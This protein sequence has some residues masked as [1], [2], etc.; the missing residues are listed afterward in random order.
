MEREELPDLGRRDVLGNLS[1]FIG[2]GEEETRRSFAAALPASM[3]AIAEHGSSER[4]ARDLMEGMRSGEAPQLDVNDVAATLSDAQ[5]SDRLLVRSG[6]WLERLLGGRMNGILGALSTHGGL[7]RDATSKVMALAAPLALGLVG[8]RVREDGL[9]ADALADFL[10]SEKD[11][12]GAQVPAPLL[13]LLG[14]ERAAMRDEVRPEAS[15]LER[16]PWRWLFVIVAS[17]I[18]LGYLVFRGERPVGRTVGAPMI[19]L[20]RPAPAVT[21]ES[22]GMRPLA[23]FLSS[24]QKGEQRFVANNLTFTTDERG[25]TPDGK[26][27]AAELAAQLRAHPNAHVRIEGFSDATGDASANQQI[28]ERR[29]NVVKRYLVD[30]G[31]SADRVEA[32]GMGAEQPLAAEGKV[33]SRPIALEVRNP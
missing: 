8:R 19:R 16:G 5:A 14:E 9:D 3:Y 6:A 31:V 15:R 26:R 28:S 22:R 7:G 17:V 33:Q 27:V 21:S 13:A 18:G 2:G 1:R 10:R 30:H 32:V 12:V 29:A 23:D 20:R 25:L 4:G 24:G 11:K